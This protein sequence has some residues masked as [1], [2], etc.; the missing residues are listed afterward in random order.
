MI[1]KSLASPLKGGEQHLLHKARL[2]LKVHSRN[3]KT[4]EY[5]QSSKAQLWYLHRLENVTL[6][7][8]DTEK[9]CIEIN[10]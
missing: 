5:S 1:S 3:R 10:W 7:P 8:S 4:P 2:R 6:T 9:D